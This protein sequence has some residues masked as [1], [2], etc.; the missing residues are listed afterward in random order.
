M[1]ASR[2]AWLTSAVAGLLLTAS[3]LNASS[4]LTMSVS[5]TIGTAPAYVI[6]TVTV[7]RDADNRELEVAAESANFF[8]SSLISLDGERAPRTNQIAWK[9]LP[10]GEYAVVAVLYG[11][12]GQRQSVQRS[13]V[14][15]PSSQDR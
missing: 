12:D 6:A 3:G 9:D 13:V 8:R 5:P 10:G 2:I 1:T 7:E 4:K 11:K 15:T 14:I